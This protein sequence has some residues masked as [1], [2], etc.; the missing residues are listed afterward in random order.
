MAI[1]I[2]VSGEELDRIRKNRREIEERL[3]DLEGL[4][5]TL[6][7]LRYRFLLEQREKL[8]RKLEEMRVHYEELVE[9]EEKAKKDREY[10][11]EVRQ[12]LSLENEK[13]RKRLEG[14]E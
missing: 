11:I 12:R 10:L 3:K 9:F 4:E 14:K 8:L 7:I 5:R 1:E 6:R 2:E 13:L